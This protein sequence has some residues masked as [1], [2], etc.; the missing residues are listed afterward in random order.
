MAKIKVFTLFPL[1][2]SLFSAS[3]CRQ[4]IGERFLVCHPLFPFDSL[5]Y[6]H[7][8]DHGRASCQVTCVSP[9]DR[10]CDWVL[11][12][13]ASARA[14]EGSVAYQLEALDPVSD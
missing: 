5:V 14:S 11:G 9:T 7:N 6:S 4:M 8:R 2:V 10:T 1:L 3:T 13:R 12:N